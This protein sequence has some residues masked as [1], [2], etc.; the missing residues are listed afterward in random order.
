MRRIK[1]SS[2]IYL[3]PSI[4]L[5]I[6]NVAWTQEQQQ[7][8]DLHHQQSSLQQNF[9]K[10]HCADENQNVCLLS[11]TEKD[12]SIVTI[13]V[14]SIACYDFECKNSLVIAGKLF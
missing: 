12:N 1:V 5:L 10:L 7:Q 3:I 2:N 14:S 13:R 8:Q 9:Y 11:T 4:L 6:L